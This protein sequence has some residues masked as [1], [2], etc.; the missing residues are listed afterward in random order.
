M[1]TMFLKDM[2]AS[3]KTVKSTMCAKCGKSYD[4]E[5]SRPLARRRKKIDRADENASVVWE[6]LHESC[7]D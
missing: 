5:S 1:L 2:I 3:Y 6:A 7:L 4:A